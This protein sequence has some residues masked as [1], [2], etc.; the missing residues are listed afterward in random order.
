VCPLLEKEKRSFLPSP[1]KLYLGDIGLLTEGEK[2]N[3]MLIP[4]PVGK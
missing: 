2:K 4:V 1:T 3:L